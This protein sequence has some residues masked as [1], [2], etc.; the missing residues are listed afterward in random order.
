MK[1]SIISSAILL[2]TL[3]IITSCRKDDTV[4]DPKNLFDNFITGRQSKPQLFTINGA[5]GG[6]I[7]GTGASKI[8]FPPNAFSNASG[9]IFTGDAIVELKESLK[10][11]SWV[12]DGL[13]ATTKTGL[14]QS[15]GML[16]ILVKRKDNGQELF[17]APAMQIPNPANLNAVIKVEVPRNANAQNLDMNLFLPDSSLA[18]PASTPPAA[19]QA[20]AYSPFNSGA[21]GYVFQLP[22]FRW[23]N[24][25][26]LYSQP[27]AKTTIK[28]TPVLTSFPGATQMQGMLVYRN[29]ATAINLPAGAGF[30]ESYPNSITVG[31]VA[32]VVCLGKSADGKILF[33]VL[34]ATSFTAGMNVAITPVVS[35]AAEVSAYLDSID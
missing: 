27:G 1:K 8:S 24:C 3:T 22:K 12:A 26:V 10:K 29:I 33:K 14:L 11:S 7:T 19:W 30:F 20:A 16:D 15:G 2:L 32:D 13:S 9:I 18:Q 6:S 4:A 23:V 5:A 31:S 34:P 25:D 35:T 21:N 17:P 28:V